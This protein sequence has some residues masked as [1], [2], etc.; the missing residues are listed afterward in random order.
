MWKRFEA[1]LMK[2][3][4]AFSQNVFLDTTTRSFTMIFPFMMIGSGFLLIK[5][6]TVKPRQDFFDRTRL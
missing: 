4:G 5:G 1:V 3:A 2:W 6:V